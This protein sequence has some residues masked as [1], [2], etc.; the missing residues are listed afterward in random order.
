MSKL[1]LSDHSSLSAYQH[2]K[3]EEFLFSAPLNVLP[4]PKIEFL[5]QISCF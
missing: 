4:T 5:Q 2:R 3:I 1:H